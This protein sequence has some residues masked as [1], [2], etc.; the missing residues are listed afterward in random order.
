MCYF[1]L[2]F[3]KS[4]TYLSAA[5]CI[6]LQSKIVIDDSRNSPDLY[7]WVLP[8]SFITVAIS[9]KIIT[10]TQYITRFYE[11]FESLYFFCQLENNE[12]IMKCIIYFKEIDFIKFFLC[13]LIF[14]IITNADDIFYLVLCFI[15]QIKTSFS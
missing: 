11:M 7:F 8:I 15:G 3:G 14:I 12:I 5:K 9:A 13:L 10:F 1:S 6:S 4:M 2:S